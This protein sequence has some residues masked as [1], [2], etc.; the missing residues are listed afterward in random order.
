MHGEISL[1][2]GS[3]HDILTARQKGRWLAEQVGFRGSETILLSTLISELVRKVYSTARH[4]RVLLRTIEQGSARGIIIEVSE[5][6]QY[7]G[8]HADG[9]MRTRTSTPYATVSVR[10]AGR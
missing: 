7:P 8:G 1:L 2:I 9:H 4:G 5:R 10:V 3:E 6:V